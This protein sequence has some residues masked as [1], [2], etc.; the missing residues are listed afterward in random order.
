M[1]QEKNFYFIDTRDGAKQKEP[2]AIKN[3][4]VAKSWTRDFN[5][6][7]GP[8]KP[9]SEEEFQKNRRDLFEESDGRLSV[10]VEAEQTKKNL[11]ILEADHMAVANIY[12]VEDL[13]NSPYS[14]MDKDELKAELEARNIEFKK[15]G[16]ESTKET[17][18]KLLLDDDLKDG[19]NE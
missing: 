3:P 4:D 6:G 19:S 13:D 10:H 11:E 15:S 18:Q 8:F 12:A 14:G 16:P 9:S 2:F 5:N 1:A 17:Y 7:E